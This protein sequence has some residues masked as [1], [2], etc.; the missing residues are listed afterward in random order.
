[1]P[2]LVPTPPEPFVVVPPPPLPLLGPVVVGPEPLVVEV[3]LVVLDP[4]VLGPPVPAPPPPA[5]DPLV[6]GP[7]SIGS[8]EAQPTYARAKAINSSEIQR[9]DSRMSFNPGGA[10]QYTMSADA[11]LHRT[12][13]Q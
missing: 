2:L 4:E 8:S 11:V 10:E 9:R 12:E 5:V 3:V 7:R 13:A 6:S 1:V